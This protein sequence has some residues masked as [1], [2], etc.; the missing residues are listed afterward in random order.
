MQGL[1]SWK[2]APVIWG[3]ALQA[4]TAVRALLRLG[5]VA[6][7]FLPACYVQLSLIT[8]RFEMISVSRWIS[9][10]PL[11]PFLLFLCLKSRVKVGFP[12]SVEAEGVKTEWGIW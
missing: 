1:Y 2:A 5:L 10:L 4:G 12:V 9:T 8:C 6:L 7:F 3:R 11:P